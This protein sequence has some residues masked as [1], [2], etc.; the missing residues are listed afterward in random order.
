MTDE[1]GA[2]AGGENFEE[3]EQRAGGFGRQFTSYEAG[4]GRRFEMLSA[5]IE[6]MNRLLASIHSYMRCMT[7]ILIA[8]ALAAVV[9]AVLAYTGWFSFTQALD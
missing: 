2:V 1:P 8:A 9:M 7:V 6:S 4:I 3:L 5:Q